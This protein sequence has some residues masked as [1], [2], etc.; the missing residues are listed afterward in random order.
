[1]PSAA[2]KT[3][4]LLLA[5]L[6][7]VGGCVAPGLEPAQT[8][9]LSTETPK[10]DAFSSQLRQAVESGD[11]DAMRGLMDDSLFVIAFWPGNS[12]PPLPGD[13]AIG[14]LRSLHMTGGPIRFPEPDA[15]LSEMLGGQDPVH[16]FQSDVPVVDVLFS[17][18]WGPEGLGE[19]MLFVAQRPD[20]SHWWY[21]II[22]A[23]NGFPRVM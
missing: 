8:Q 15:P 13:D 20:G 18:G 17:Q 16:I 12:L 9:P 22:I 4:T 21:S 11:S 6:L 1:M 5:I 2:Q 19:A 7:F 23:P 3:V 10:P 14:Q